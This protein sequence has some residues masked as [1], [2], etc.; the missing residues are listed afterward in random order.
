VDKI[1][2]FK[3]WIHINTELSLSSVNHY[4][5]A[6]NTISKEMLDTGIIHKR[7]MD[8]NLLELDVS[9]FNIFKDDGF[10]KKD[11]TGRRMYSSALKWFRFYVLEN[12]EDSQAEK[13][14]ENKIA[15]SNELTQTEKDTIIKARVGQGR[16]R[17]SLI[18]KY[19]GKCIVTGIDVKKLLIASHI[20]PWSASNNNERVDTENGLLLSA[21]MD[22]LF[23]GG[24]ITFDNEGKMVVSRFVGE[25]NKTRLHIDNPITV[26]LKDSKR[27]ISY[28]EY[29]RDVLFVK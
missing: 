24:L 7:L 5:G 12:F 22:R 17:T 9:I 26:N 19:N 13:D 1:N 10:V 11:Q 3:E 4:T 25:A 21:N 16:Y 23:D 6:V 20:K 29:H 15:A 28:L 14:I 27:M 8:M 18:N 2:A